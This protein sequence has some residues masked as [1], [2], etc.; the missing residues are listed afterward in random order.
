MN[1]LRQMVWMASL[2][3]ETVVRSR[4]SLIAAL[5]VALPL[6]FSAYGALLSPGDGGSPEGLLA[7]YQF[8]GSS[9]FLVQFLALFYGLGILAEEME[10]GTLVYLF[11]RPVSRTSFV[12]GRFVAALGVVLVLLTVLNGCQ[13]ALA[14]TLAPLRALVA[15]ELPLLLGAVAYLAVFSL[16][17]SLFRK[18]LAPALLYLIAW[19][20][21]L[22]LVA[23][24]VRYGTIKFHL[25]SLCHG[26]AGAAPDPTAIGGEFFVLCDAPQAVSVAFLAGVTAISLA[27]T[28][29]RVNRLQIQ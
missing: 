18:P 2:Y 12:A 7:S 13:V 23:L 16:F 9:G 11:V 25:L 24:P 19:E 14:G 28:V 4:R 1:P 3:W 10:N 27:L 8:L 21:G 6:L 20:L 17:S 5:L 26:L 29:Y 22:S 15:V